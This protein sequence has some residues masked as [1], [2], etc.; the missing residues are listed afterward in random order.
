MITT[1]VLVILGIAL[2]FVLKTMFST[3]GKP[4]PIA[5]APAAAQLPDALDLDA[6]DAKKGDVVSINGAAADFSDVDFP[7]DRRSAY[8]ANNRRWIDLSGLY[9]GQRVYL[10][11]YRYPTPDY[12]AIVD[13]RKLT[14]ADIALTEEQLADM[15]TRQDPSAFVVFEGKQW[16]YESSR[17]I[18]YFENETGAGEG[19]YRWL[20]AEPNGSGLI[21]VEK[22]EGEP[23]EVRLARHFNKRDITVYRAA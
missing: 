3:P 21:C 20:F 4:K 7:V 22:W 2:V 12:V 8:E 10:E 19:L 5:A 18:G 14:I 9:R 6:W 1:I 23:F 13:P 11:I 15:D 16:H 17:E